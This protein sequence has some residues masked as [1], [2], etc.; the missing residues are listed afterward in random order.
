M[1]R[2]VWCHSRVFDQR[3]GGNNLDNHGGIVMRRSKA[4][5]LDIA[6]FH[7][8]GKIDGLEAAV[9]RHNVLGTDI[10]ILFFA[11]DVVHVV[12]TPSGAKGKAT[13]SFAVTTK[14]SPVHVA[15]QDKG[16]TVTMRSDALSVELD[17]VSGRLRFLSP[18]GTS[19][20]AE[21]PD[22]ASFTPA[23]YGRDGEVADVRP[24]QAFRLDEDESLYGLGQHQTGRMDQRNQRLRLCQV[25]MESAV[26]FVQSTKGYGLFWDNPSPTVFEDS[27]TET[28]FTSDCGGRIDYYFIGGGSPGA[29]LSRL[30]RLTGGVPLPPLWA[31]GY[32]QSK[33]RYICQRELVD[34]VRRYRELGVPLDV[35]IQDWR[36]WGGTRIG[37][38]WKGVKRAWNSMV[39]R[40]AT[41]PNAKRAFDRIHAMNAHALISIWPNFG[42][43][44]AAYASMKSQ[45]HL[46]CDGGV[47]ECDDTTAIYDA[48][49]NDARDHYWELLNKELAPSGVDG[50]WMDASEPEH[51]YKP[52][53]CMWPL[54]DPLDVPT[55]A[56]DFRAVHNSYP[57]VHVE[58]VVRRQLRDF[59]DRRPVV[60]TRSAYA[61]QQRTGS[62]VWSGDVDSSWAA[63]RRQFAAGLNFSMSG[64][65]LWN[66]D[67]G[68]FIGDREFPEGC[69]SEG[70]RE[71]YVRWLQF[72]IFCPMMR[73]HG[74]CT[75]REIWNFG[76]RGDWAF[77]AI[78]KGI[79]LRYALLPYIYSAAWGIAKD[80]GA[81]MTPVALD[82]PGNPALR[83]VSDEFRFGPS[84]LVAPV[85][86]PMYVKDGKADFSKVR[87]RNVML[88][89]G[90]WWCARS[91]KRVSGKVIAKAP[92]D[93][94]PVFAKVGS[95]IPIGPD[96]QFS[97]EKPWDNLEVRVYPG[98]DGSFTLYED[99]FEGLGYTR[100]EHTEITFSWDDASRTLSISSRNGAYPGMIGER[101][102]RVRN[103]GQAREVPVRYSGKT[104]EIGL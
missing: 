20:L 70:F 89:Q 100:G 31:F 3:A 71:L 54:D 101:V 32:C 61:G 44:T 84:L 27:P 41:F 30:Q 13:P 51:N 4:R 96:A 81:F 10:S 29:V 59:P 45:G 16:G 97:T 104:V 65:P 7:L 33:E 85:V 43:D 38:T 53:V 1:A 80:G 40:K 77:D 72:G 102:F 35:I 76:K 88:P 5:G 24:R 56:G 28:S 64:I 75:P 73:S 11:P 67:I 2:D 26:P 90:D 95:I 46:M 21:K 6:P 42:R 69:K 78:E 99:A 74:T 94:I 57:I 49:N 47:A 79:R 98:A 50:W 12:K 87:G 55:A 83:D 9:V 15:L 91:E 103:A 22:G 19:L 48:W 62:F 8:E 25:N 18:G 63:F 82:D 14:P 17:K 37:R 58:G 36:Y 66:S 92:I 93:E 23:T 60:L 68:G 52:L 39:F 34:A 86:E